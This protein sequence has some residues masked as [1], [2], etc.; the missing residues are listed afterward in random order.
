MNRKNM[1]LLLM[2]VSGACTCIV[3]LVR[4]YSVLA[5]LMALFF[6]MLLFYCLGS[7]LCWLLN[8]FERQNE[9]RERQEQEAKA[10]QEQET[11]AS[12]EGAEQKGVNDSNG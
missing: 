7:L 3:T 10:A 2:L 12:E 4:Q 11:A 9:E 8:R 1:P 5:S 6:V